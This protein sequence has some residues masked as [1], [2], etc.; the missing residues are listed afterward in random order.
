MSE[1]Y[2]FSTPLA[3][4]LVLSLFYFIGCTSFGGSDDAAGFKVGPDGKPDYPGT[5]EDEASLVSY[6]RLQ[7]KKV[8]QPPT[9]S[10]PNVPVTGGQANDEKAANNGSY[11]SVIVQPLPKFP[12]SPS[13]PGT[14]TLEESGL[15]ELSVA[16]TSLFVDGGFV[17]VPYSNSLAPTSFSVEALVSPGWSPAEKGLYRTLI[18][19]NRL[20]VDPVTG[21]IVK[22]FGFGLFAG[23]ENPATPGPDVW[24]IWLADGTN[25][26]MIKDSTR[27]LTLVDFTKTN[28]VAVTYDATTSKLNMYTYVEK[29]DLDSDAPHPIK[30]V[31]A[32]FSPVNDPTFSL[33]IGMHRPPKNSGTV[34]LYHP[35]KGKIQE[36]AF[37]KSAL[38]VDRCPASHV[39]A[40][41]N[42]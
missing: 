29:I 3:V 20:E 22:A 14:L 25:W 32:A 34:P 5:I 28:Y 30:D 4:L 40:G 12:D 17:E 38:S 11:K 27:N 18:S 9:P 21:S 24:Q 41:L 8:A 39:C 6:W 23:P 36:V 10:A 19:L 15:L 16:G 33:L 37:Y 13:A 7:E 26:K 2:L 31:T 1:W 35:F 42:L